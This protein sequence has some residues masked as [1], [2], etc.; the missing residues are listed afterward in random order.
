MENMRSGMSEENVK[1]VNL[2]IFTTKE[3]Q[4][5]PSVM[6]DT[7]WIVFGDGAILRPILYSLNILRANCFQ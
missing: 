1:N 5:A 7:S 4:S 6:I 3:D 2:K